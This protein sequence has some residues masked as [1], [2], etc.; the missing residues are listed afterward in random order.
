MVRHLSLATLALAFVVGCNNAPNPP[1]GNPPSGGATNRKVQVNAPGV[2]VEVEGKG[3]TDKRG[4]VKVNAPGVDV[5]VQR[6]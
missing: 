3:S 4:S 5:D 2:N 6:K 1:S